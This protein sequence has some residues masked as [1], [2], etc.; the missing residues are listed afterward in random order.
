[1]VG[2]EVARAG[3]PICHGDEAR[4]RRWPQLGRGHGDGRARDRARGEGRG[5]SRRRGG[6]EASER[7]QVGER[8][9]SPRRQGV[10]SLST[11]A[12]TARWVRRGRDLGAHGVG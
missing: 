12:P 10:E 8:G 9:E 3:E 6:A 11:E 2:E 4:W 7:G 5:G 1:M